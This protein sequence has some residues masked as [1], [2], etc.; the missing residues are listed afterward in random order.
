[1]FIRWDNHIA[2]IETL[3]P[4]KTDAVK[5]LDTQDSETPPRYARFTVNTG[6]MEPAAIFEYIVGPLPASA[7]TEIVPLSFPYN[8][9]RNHVVNPL[10]S[11]TEIV[12]WLANLGH[13][14]SDM[15]K[16]LL[17][18]VV[19]PNYAG[20]SPQL[21]P[22]S[23][24]AALENGT[25]SSWANVRAAGLDS[26][27]FSLLAQGLHCKIVIPGRDPSQWKVEKWFY[28]GIL[29]SSTREF[30]RA[31][32]EGKV[33]KL[34]PNRD[35]EWT[36]AQPDHDGIPGREKN[37]PIMIQPGGPRYKID[38]REKH[39]SWMGFE[40]YMNAMQ[41]TGI[42][43]W[44]IK[45]RG[46]RV[47]Y[48]IGLQEAMAHYAGND[49]SSS[50][51]VWLDT[52]FGMGLN[53]YELVKGYDCPAYATYLPVTFRQGD[54]TITRNNSIC[55][56]EYTADHAIQR[57]TTPNHISISKNSYLVVRSVSTVGN[58][59]YTIDYLFYLDGS[60]EVKVR[61]SGY[62]FGAYHQLEAMRKDL[63]KKSEVPSYEYGYQIQ[64]LVVS[65]MHDHGLNF[66]ADLDIAGTANTLYKVEVSP[67]HHKYPWDDTERSTMHLVHTPIESE[68]GLDWPSNSGAMYVVLNNDSTN[69]WGEKR[70]YRITSGTG[71]GTPPH[72]TIANSTGLGDAANWAYHDFWVLKQHDWERRSSSEFNFLDPTD[73]L[74]DFAKMVDG[75]AVVQ[76]D[77]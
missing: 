1:M 29:Y 21:M 34:P 32:K 64:D 45:F 16:D 40:F 3:I 75:E 41:A 10:P 46:E 23:R 37:S 61:A 19:D 18:D 25:W 77:L 60:I 20:G 39:V 51:M 6:T 43:L 12:K 28:N 57:H 22:L 42:A 59:D 63:D 8:S 31:W 36:E 30:R 72:L 15:I 14:N 70:G 68:I 33:V 47:L 26:G 52:F 17:G 67:H 53:M 9:G 73:P 71:M 4:N 48:E 24:T 74:I 50:N 76:D 55:V 38:V 11:Y 62:I 54:G 66:K 44:D 2:I 65:S 58:Y 56:F 7:Q 69:A 13:K 27:A 49:P 35:G 5:Y